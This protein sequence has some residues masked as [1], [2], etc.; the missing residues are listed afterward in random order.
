MLLIIDKKQSRFLGAIFWFVAN[1]IFWWF[2]ASLI[3]FCIILVQR[4]S[5]SVLEA[6]LKE[7]VD[8]KEAALQITLHGPDNN[9][10][11]DWTSRQHGTYSQKYLDDLSRES[12][13]VRDK[14][15]LDAV[16]LGLLYKELLKRNS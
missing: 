8:R 13:A 4:K 14:A 3:D 6:R 12:V 11:E 2:V 7:N 5:R 1:L 15:A 9:F 16:K 10:S